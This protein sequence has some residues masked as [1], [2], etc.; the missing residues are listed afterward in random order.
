MTT[1]ALSDGAWLKIRP[2]LLTFALLVGALTLTSARAE[3]ISIS[4]ATFIQQCPCAQSGNVPTLDRGVLKP[5]DFAKVYADVAFPTAGQEICS[6]SIVYQDINGAENMTA[7]LFRKSF[8]LGGNAFN[9]P[10][11]IATVS[12]ANGVVEQVRRTTTTAVNPRS[13]GKGNSFYYVEVT[14]PNI[15]LN[16][17]GVQ[18]DYRP[19]CPT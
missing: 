11:A 8:N 3:I 17:I 14:F 19:V 1:I 15:N 13:I 10:V 5:T 12:S 6:L 7:R 16:L 2:A 9:P 18:I 4:G